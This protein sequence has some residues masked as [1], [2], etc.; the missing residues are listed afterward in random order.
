MDDKT[1]SKNVK[2]LLELGKQSFDF[3]EEYG[4]KD[5]GSYSSEFNDSKIEVLA[6]K[7]KETIDLADKILKRFGKVSPNIEKVKE[8]YP[9]L[10]NT[11]YALKEMELEIFIDKRVLEFKRSIKKFLSDD[12]TMKFE[13]STNKFLGDLIPYESRTI[14][15]HPEMKEVF[16]AFKSRKK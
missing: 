1:I 8:L 12:N 15:K 5:Y 3:V 16:I 2:E 11:F 14:E 6:A 7:K 9:E 10:V 4:T 13:E